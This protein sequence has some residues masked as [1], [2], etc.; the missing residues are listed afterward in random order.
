MSA[1][2]GAADG[3]PGDPGDKYE[4]VQKVGK[5]AFGEVW[6]A[7]VKATGE[8][9][10]VKEIKLV[11]GAE[12]AG[13]DKSAIDEIC[14]MQELKHE[15]VLTLIEVFPARGGT[16]SMVLELVATDLE[17]IMRSSK[18]AGELFIPASEIKAY[19]KMLLS[20]MHY[21]HT[22]YILHRDLKPANLLITAEGVLKLCDFGLARTFGSPSGRYSPEA[23]TIWYRPMELLLGA[24][25]YGPPCDMW[26]VGCIFG[27]MMLR[28]PILASDPPVEMKQIERIIELLGSPSEKNWPHMEQLPGAPA[29]G[30]GAP[31]LKIRFK[32]R[33]P[34]PLNQVFT[35]ASADAIHLIRNLLLYDPCARL[36]AA[37]A[38]DHPYI[39]NGEPPAPCS[40]IAQR[41][42]NMMA[43][44]DNE[45][46]AAHAEAPEAKHG[47]KRK[48]ADSPVLG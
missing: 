18:E 32:P 12:G 5:G 38:L 39:T 47:L 26:G 46:Q 33:E 9:V 11:S 29:K 25:R 8:M 21:C 44:R 19:M 45:K 3:G 28:S 36:S 43:K 40:A 16:L 4:M 42:A 24:E 1:G 27:E 10:A 7:R 20:A 37:Q 34:F 13:F 6:K 31:R 15:N 35:A 2:A 48:A 17:V 41:V 23:I 30:K 14:V 22:N